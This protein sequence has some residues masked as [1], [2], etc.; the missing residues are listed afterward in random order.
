M[1][2]R[3]FILLVIT[4]TS[5]ASTQERKSQWKRIFPPDQSFTF[6]L[7][8]NPSFS[9]KTLNGKEGRVELNDW[10]LKSR[11]ARPLMHFSHSTCST[12]IPAEEACEAR[13]DAAQEATIEELK[14]RVISVKRFQLREHPGKEI[15]LKLPD[16]RFAQVRFV[17]VRK[18]VFTL[19]VV[20]KKA[21]LESFEARVFF[22]SFRLRGAGPQ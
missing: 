14:G 15:R 3:V 5:V 12:A 10:V 13:I 4:S 7:P 1:F 18:H 22:R 2:S 9:T 8:E 6:L 11:K 19:L 20:G 21:E 16:G 17:A